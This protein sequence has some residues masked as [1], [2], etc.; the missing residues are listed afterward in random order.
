MRLGPRAAFGLLLGVTALLVAAGV[1]AFLQ[2]E[3][4]LGALFVAAGLA[5]FVLVAR[6]SGPGAPEGPFPPAWRSILEE[7]VGYY[8]R[9]DP[10]RKADFE[11]RVAAFLASNRFVGVGIEASDELKVLASAAAAMLLFGRP[12]AELPR[13]AEVLFYPGSFDEDFRTRRRGSTTMGLN[14]VFGAVVFSAPELRAGF[15]DERNGRNVGLHEFAHAIDRHLDEHDGI[16]A[17]MDDA[18]AREL[19]R[20]Q[21]GEMRKAADG[22]SVL[23]PY[24]ASNEVEFLAVATEAYFT[25]A[26]ELRQRHPELF[27]VL[28]RYYGPLPAVPDPL[29]PAKRR[30]DD[31]PAAGRRA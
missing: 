3:P 1:F 25:R 18:D 8:R 11:S 29:E 2:R 4:L 15:A 27:A 30:P 6:P 28:E 23:D 21:P 9:L 31:R 7:Q 12:G 20:L 24:A 16:P 13:V 26:P 22:A 14:S 10:P 5:G 17:G 19:I